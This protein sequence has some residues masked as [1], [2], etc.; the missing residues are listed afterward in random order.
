MDGGCYSVPE[1]VNLIRINFFSYSS[2][3]GEKFSQTRPLIGE[4]LVG[5]RGSGSR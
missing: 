2:P 5:E 1:P 4:F 3:R